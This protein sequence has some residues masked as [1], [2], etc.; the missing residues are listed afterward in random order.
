MDQANTLSDDARVTL[1]AAAAKEA[2]RI[3]WPIVDRLDLWIEAPLVPMTRSQNFLGG[4]SSLQVRERVI[5]ARARS[6]KSVCGKRAGY[7][8]RAHKPRTGREERLQRCRQGDAYE[9]RRAPQ[10]LSRSVITAPCGS[11]APSPTSPAPTPSRRPSS[12]KRLKW[13]RDYLRFNK[14]IV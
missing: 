1:R 9:L 2:R 13:S 8:R 14:I 7:K 5:A 3:S 11:R 4:E 6:G 12:T 10:P